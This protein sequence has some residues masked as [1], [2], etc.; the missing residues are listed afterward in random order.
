MVEDFAVAVRSRSQ[1][2]FTCHKSPHGKDNYGK[3]GDERTA[4]RGDSRLIPIRNKQVHNK[5][6]GKYHNNRK[7]TGSAS[8]HRQDGELAL[9]QKT[10]SNYRS[11]GDLLPNLQ[12]NPRKRAA[13]RTLSE[14]D[15]A[16]VARYVR[17]LSFNLI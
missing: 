14:E 4:S 6:A 12:N 2:S 8:A 16:K 7:R 13:L 1:N 5:R 11:I 9:I 10:T 15:G 3:S 17:F